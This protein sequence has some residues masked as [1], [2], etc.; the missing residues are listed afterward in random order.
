MR[1]WTLAPDMKHRSVFCPGRRETGVCA[2]SLRHLSTVAW[3][4]MFG[5]RGTIS[6]STTFAAPTGTI[7]LNERWRACAV[8]EILI[9]DVADRALA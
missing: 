5:S 8:A 9:A 1:C 2:G 3:K 7:T 6:V 4:E